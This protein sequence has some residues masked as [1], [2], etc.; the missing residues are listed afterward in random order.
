[1]PWSACPSSDGGMISPSALAVL[2]LITSSNFVGCSM[3]R[4]AGLAPLRILSTYHGEAAGHLSLVLTVG[5]EAAVDGIGP[6]RVDRR[7]P[8][9]DREVENLPPIGPRDGHIDY[10]ERAEALTQDR[11]E[12]RVD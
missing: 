5:H 9:P 6:V 7:Q 12:G 11:I 2:R 1:M 8:V 10:V 3:G 4:S